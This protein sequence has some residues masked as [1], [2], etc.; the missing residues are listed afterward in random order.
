MYISTT[1]VFAALCIGI[2]ILFGAA[3]MIDRKIKKKLQKEKASTF[4]FVVNTM[5]NGTLC[6]DFYERMT[7]TGK[8]L[9][10]IVPGMDKNA[11]T[12]F[13]R[14]ACLLRSLRQLITDREVTAFDVFSEPLQFKAIEFATSMGRSGLAKELTDFT[15]NFCEKMSEAAIL[16]LFLTIIK[17]DQRFVANGN[18]TLD[19]ST[20][21]AAEAVLIYGM[22]LMY[23]DNLSQSSLAID[24]KK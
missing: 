21:F 7:E 1:I 18:F 20:V 12:T 11:L 17:K 3:F 8:N 24:L 6:L 14:G 2:F 22:S 13:I 15:I 23:I 10:L 19:K 5:I 16:D 4:I 9:A